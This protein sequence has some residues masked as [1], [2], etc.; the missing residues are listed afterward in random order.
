MTLSDK[1]MA[2]A[3]A[4]AAKDRDLLARLQ[5]AGEVV[6]V[7]SGDEDARAFVA[8]IERRIV[9]RNRRKPDPTIIPKSKRRRR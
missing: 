5:A 8:D 3:E 1:A 6:R 4:Q 9:V 2:L 7:V